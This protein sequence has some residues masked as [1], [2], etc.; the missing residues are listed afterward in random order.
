M[1]LTLSCG[2]KTDKYVWNMAWN[3]FRLGVKTRLEAVRDIR[4]KNGRSP[5]PTKNRDDHMISGSKTL[6]RTIGRLLLFCAVSSSALAQDPAADFRQNCV[7][8]HTISG[9]RLTGPDLKN[10]GQRKDRDWLIRFISDPRAVIDSG[11]PYALELLAQARNAVMPTLPGMTRLRAEALLRLIEEESTLEKSRFV[12]IHISDRP[13]TANDVEIGRMLFIGR[14][15]LKNGGPSCISCHTVHGLG[16]LGGGT[17]APDLTTV[18]ERYEGRKALSTWLSAPATPTM[19]SV[20]RSNAIDGDEILPLVAYF[21]Q[22]LQR[23]PEDTATSRLNFVLLG[24][25]GTIVVLGLFDVIWKG[26][27]KSVRRTLVHRQE[28]E[29]QHA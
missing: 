13:F 26:R 12:G 23:N 27:F 16:A 1:P 19:Q 25:G 22:T 4:T 8:C 7:S 17:L 5:G 11:D 6:K 3:L 18:F 21:Q 29:K 14:R 24:L 10:V 28:S 9:G 15:P 2:E 20:F